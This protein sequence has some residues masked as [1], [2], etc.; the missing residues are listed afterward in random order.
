[1]GEKKIN[2]TDFLVWGIWNIEM[3]RTVVFVLKLEW[4]MWG[5]DYLE[6]WYT[7]HN[8]LQGEIMLTDSDAF[9]NE[10]QMSWTQDKLWFMFQCWL[11]AASV[12]HN[13]ENMIIKNMSQCVFAAGMLF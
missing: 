9:Q 11:E 7:A 3:F 13:V 10:K 12:F 4:I 2:K 6:K 1:M 5:L 8:P